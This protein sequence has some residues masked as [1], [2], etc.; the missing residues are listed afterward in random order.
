M[1]NGFTVNK[2]VKV[3]GE[4]YFSVSGKLGAMSYWR[5]GPFLTKKE[6]DKWIAEKEKNA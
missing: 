4:K 1:K 3:K 6:A 2:E 5:I